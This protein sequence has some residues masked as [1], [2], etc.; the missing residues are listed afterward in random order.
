MSAP[1][2]PCAPNGS[3]DLTSLVASLALAP[4]PR[5]WRTRFAGVEDA[6]T[7]SRTC[8]RLRGPFNSKIT[9]MVITGEPSAGSVAGLLSHRPA[10]VADPAG[11]GGHRAGR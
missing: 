10:R 7:A 3:F 2:G 4:P 9:A 1:A 5:T 11:A 8:T 6:V